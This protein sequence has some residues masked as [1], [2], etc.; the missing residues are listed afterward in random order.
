MATG[1]SIV[2]LHKCDG[3]VSGILTI[4]HYDEVSARNLCKL[5]IFIKLGSPLP[6]ASRATFT[7][8]FMRDVVVRSAKE[9]E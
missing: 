9:R 6:P 8:V 7:G 2:I 4:V 5:L 3:V 1:L